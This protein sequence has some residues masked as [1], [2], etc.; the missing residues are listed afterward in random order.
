MSIPTVV[1]VVVECAHDTTNGRIYEVDKDL[2]SSVDVEGG[3][4]WIKQ[5][6]IGEQYYLYR[7]EF[8]VVA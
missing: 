3:A 5:D 4:V 2:T 8:E 7:N 1:R 6:D